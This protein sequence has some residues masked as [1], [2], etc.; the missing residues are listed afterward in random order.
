MNIAVAIIGDGRQQYL[1]QA[2]A[3]LEQ[4]I[5]QSA[6]E[7]TI[8]INDADG[9]E[10]YAAYLESTYPQMTRFV[11][12]EARRGLAGA[13]RSAWTAAL[14]YD[15]DFIWHAEEDFVLTENVPIAQMMYLLTERP[16]LA[17]L[18]LNRPPDPGN[19]PEVA[20][21]GPMLTAPD[22]YNERSDGDLVWSEHARI[23]SFNPML[24]SRA[25]IECA[26][27]NCTDFL[28]AGVTTTLLQNGFTFAFWGG[29]FDPPKCDHVG[30]QRS[31]GYRW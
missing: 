12:H 3:S 7:A 26:L 30:L 25:A 6:V 1:S 20:A 10:V 23:F 16:Y 19:A 8:M 14:E 5:P 27:E 24:A 17:Q 13:V 15:V 21:G 4:H 29:K 2:V 28:E 11:H 22:Q 31:S 9:D 18:V